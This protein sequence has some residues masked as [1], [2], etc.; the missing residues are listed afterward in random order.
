MAAPV[1]L[2]RNFKLLEEVR[3]RHNLDVSL[4]ESYKF[5]FISC[6]LLCNFTYLAQLE[7]SEKG[8]GDMSISLGLVQPDDILL[9]DWNGSIL[10]PPGVSSN[11][12]SFHPFL[13]LLNIHIINYA[14][15]PRIRTGCMS[16][17]ST[18]APTTPCGP[19]RCASSPAS[20]SPPWTNARVM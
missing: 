6:E 1:I 8:H 5:N 20:T 7:A 16:C 4:L 9:K 2:P 3:K 17:E 14:T 19:P 13:S 15:R 12:R 18:A 10:G 11:A